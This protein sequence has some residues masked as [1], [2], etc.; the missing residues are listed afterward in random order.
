[1]KISVRTDYVF[2]RES[3]PDQIRFAKEAGADAIEYGEM[4]GYDCAL[5]ADTAERLD[6]PFAACGFYDMWNCRL[7]DD[8]GRIQANLLKTVE[9]A[10]ILGCRFLLGLTV[11]SLKREEG[12][13]AR[14][15]ENMKPVADLLEKNDLVVLIEPHNTILPN[16]LY[17]FSHYFVNSCALGAELIQRIGS[18]SVRLLVDVYHEQIT[19]GN[20]F[21]TI[22]NN[23]PVISHYHFSGVPGRDEPM[24][25][26]VQ[27]QNLARKISDLG[28]DGYFGLEYF[29]SCDAKKSLTDT[30]AYLKQN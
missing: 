12:Q 9:C 14:F 7:G 8:F 21:T 26:E 19:A 28:Y 22:Q 10:K 4:L 18:T 24:H 3:I 11:D 20:L 15:V 29:P 2:G 16:P 6:I 23:F 13:K 27:Y 17:D 25:G 1:M 5:A 30:I